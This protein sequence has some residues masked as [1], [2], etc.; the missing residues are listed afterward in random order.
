MKQNTKKFRKGLNKMFECVSEA[1]IKELYEKVKMKPEYAKKY[2]TLP[3]CP[4]Q[5][6][7]HNWKGYDLPRC[8]IILDFKEWLE[9]YDINIKHLGYTYDDY[10]LEFLTGKRTPAKKTFMPYPEIDLHNFSDIFTESGIDKFD[11]FLFNQTLEHVYDPLRVVQEV[12]KV[13]EK[14]GY[15]FTS[16]PTINIMH[17][18]PNHFQGLYPIQ[19]ALLFTRSGFEIVEMGQFGNKKY[20]FK[21]FEIYG[22]P[23]YQT[24]LENGKVVNDEK[25]VCQCWILARKL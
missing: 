11:F 17:C 6:M 18:E 16:V 13:V 25:F 23:D 8:H 21:M 14:G 3:H 12:S 2:E 20:M 5:K 10:E 7:N 22:W 4:V 9:K 1:D 15:V 19:L 24:V